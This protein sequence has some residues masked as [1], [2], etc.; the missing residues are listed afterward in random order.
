LA[1]GSLFFCPRPP[2]RTCRHLVPRK[3]KFFPGVQSFCCC[4]FFCFLTL[5]ITI[6]FQ[7]VKKVKQ[8]RSPPPPPPKIEP[9]PHGGLFYGGDTMPPG[10]G[11]KKIK[12]KKSRK[13]PWVFPPPLRAP[14]PAFFFYFLAPPPRP[15]VLWG[16]FLSNILFFFFWVTP[17]PDL[18]THRPTIFPFCL[19]WKHPF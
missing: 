10:L 17:T 9:G 15:L 14:P 11:K 5:K 3:I 18:L 6:C 19:N 13:M 7:T 12:K 1:G 4:Y 8:A 16:G 2:L